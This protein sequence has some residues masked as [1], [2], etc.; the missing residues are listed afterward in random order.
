[1]PEN[2]SVL[3]TFREFPEQM[4]LRHLQTHTEKIASFVGQAVLIWSD[5]H[6]MWWRSGGSGYTSEITEAG[7]FD[8]M[9][10]WAATRHCGREKRIIFQSASKYLRKVS[11]ELQDKL[12]RIRRIEQEVK[13]H[14]RH[15]A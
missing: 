9:D 12:H 5:E 6:G 11:V 13:S 8:F 1:M 2:P 14:D 7:V 10:A 3:T 4:T 15:A